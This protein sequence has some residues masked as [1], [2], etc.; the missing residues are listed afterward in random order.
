[1]RALSPS[2]RA[3]LDCLIRTTDAGRQANYRELMQAFGFKS[4]NAANCQL[5][6]LE[7]KGYIRCSARNARSISILR[8]SNGTPYLTPLERYEA[9]CGAIGCRGV[10]FEDVLAVARARRVA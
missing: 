8:N 1:M 2:Q 3:V 9:L 6:Q 10:E 4:T 5:R 7:S